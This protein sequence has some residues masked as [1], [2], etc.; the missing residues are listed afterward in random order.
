MNCDQAF[1]CLTDPCRR[2]SPQLEE[3]LARCVRCRQMQDTLEP[4]LDLFDELVPEP[5][6]SGRTVTQTLAPESVRVAEQAASRLLAAGA[7]PPV[8][9][10]NTVLRYAAAAMIGAALMG[11]LGSINNAHSPDAGPAARAATPVDETSKCLWQKG[12][13]NRHELPTSHAVTMACLNCHN[14]LAPSP[15][16]I[17][18]EPISIEV[19]ADLSAAVDALMRDLW[20]REQRSMSTAI[21]IIPRSQG[22]VS[23]SLLCTNCADAR[24]VEFVA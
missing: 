21:A 13:V 7:Q 22:A 11:V 3:H 9:R 10:R 5:D 16:D 12:T 8:R 19:P 14:K 6:L 23:A 4:A 15:I 1:D 20:M 17:R 2:H 24:R 18:T